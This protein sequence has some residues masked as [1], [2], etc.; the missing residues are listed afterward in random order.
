MVPREIAVV[1]DLP[2]GTTINDINWP[3][4]HR[5]N[6]GGDFSYGRFLGNLHINHTS[7]AYWQDVLDVRFAGE[8]E[9]YTLVNA[10]FGVRWAG[11][12][13]VTSIKATNLANQEVMQHIFADVMKRN[14]VGEVRISF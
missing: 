10:G 7:S 2:P 6:I 12:R 8:S 9:P 3:A 14:V 5:F 11:D 4:R 1:E 13:V